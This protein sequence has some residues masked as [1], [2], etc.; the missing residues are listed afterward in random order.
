MAPS[1]ITR[2]FASVCHKTEII[3]KFQIHCQPAI[4]IKIQKLLGSLSAERQYAQKNFLKSSILPD[5]RINLSFAA[6]FHLP[7]VLPCLIKGTLLFLFM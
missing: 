4:F 7:S 5:Q 2:Q 1:G 3:T 6:A